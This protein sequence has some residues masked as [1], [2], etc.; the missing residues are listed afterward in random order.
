M[1]YIIKEV[2]NRQELKTFI[3]LPYLL[4]RN[5]KIWV[6][7]LLI[8]EKRKF[9]AKTNPMLLHC[10]FK[11]FLL[12]LNGK[13]VGRVSAFVDRLAVDFWK[14]PIGLFGSY[15]CIDSSV[16]STLLLETAR[17]WLK[18]RGMR[19]MRGPW[20]FASQE[21]G[22]VVKGFDTP[23][24]ILAPYNPD[25]YNKQMVDFGLKKAKDLLV[26]EADARRG[27]EIPEIYLKA[28][29]EI[30]QKNGI[31]VRALNLKK[32]KDDVKA[33]VEVTNKSIRPNWGFVPVTEAEA[34][35]IVRSM[36]EIVD[37]DLV[38]IAEAGGRAVGFVVVLPDLNLILKGLKGRLFPFG[39]LRLLFG[40]KKIHQYR[41]WAL[42]VIPE[43]QRLAID[44]LLYVKLHDA[45]RAKGAIRVEANYVL[46]DN[47][48]M[49][50][51]IIRLGFKE[52]KKYRVYEMPI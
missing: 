34:D 26:F 29:N 33:I 48:M 47:V 20:S 46:E 39:F 27:Y 38:L 7:P 16:G 11:L 19:R 40:M 35:D 49:K 15:E 17:T 36:K 43:Y 13:P 8:E 52:V 32:L 28:A 12:F 45:L 44:T 37:P 3:D 10:D 22:F 51:P 2:K 18:E 9:S 23:P 50:N 30:A 41:I 31:S 4:Y 21:W 24:M 5:S 42:G 25:Y 14:A 1:A 6:P